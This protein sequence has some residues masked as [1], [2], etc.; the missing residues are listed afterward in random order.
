MTP[1]FIKV[2]ETEERRR[3]LYYTVVRT[4]DRRH[5]TPSCINQSLELRTGDT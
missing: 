3:I 2:F 5:M 1:S 4:E